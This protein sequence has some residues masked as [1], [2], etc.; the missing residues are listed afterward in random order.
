M[1]EL[2]EQKIKLIISFSMKRAYH[3]DWIDA[4]PS[5][6]IDE[7]PEKSVEKNEIVKNENDGFE[8]NQDFEV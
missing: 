1:L 2:Q 7:I 6:F 5:R 3:G 8:F 4:L